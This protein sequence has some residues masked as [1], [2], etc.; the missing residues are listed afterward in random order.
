MIVNDDGA[1]SDAILGWQVELG[2]ELHH[3]EPV[4]RCKTVLPKSFNGRLRDEWLNEHL[5]ANLN[6]TPQIIEGWR[7]AC[8]ILAA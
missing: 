4:G 2:I 5:F 7:I 3:I 8:A 6:E 1:T